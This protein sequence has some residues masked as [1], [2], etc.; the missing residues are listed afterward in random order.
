MVDTELASE[1]G[2]CMALWLGGAGNEHVWRAGCHSCMLRRLG[3]Q[4][5]SG[6][7][8]RHGC[9]RTCRHGAVACDAAPT[10]EAVGGEV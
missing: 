2:C 7:P 10:A 4:P 8:S 3:E 1:E 9:K 6:V 5:A